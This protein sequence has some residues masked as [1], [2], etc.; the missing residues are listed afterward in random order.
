MLWQLL[1]WEFCAVLVAKDEEGNGGHPTT[2]PFL[3]HCHKSSKSSS[4]ASVEMIEWRVNIQ[5]MCV[6]MGQEKEFFSVPNVYSD[7]L[8]KRFSPKGPSVMHKCTK[9]I[10]W[11]E[12]LHVL[13]FKPFWDQ[14]VVHCRP[15]CDLHAQPSSPSVDVYYV[16]TMYVC[17]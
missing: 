16:V 11:F 2:N 14:N 1:V 15:I 17:A 10:N 5:C 13:Q 8:A 6:R 9:V 3:I 12:L 4:Q 7:L